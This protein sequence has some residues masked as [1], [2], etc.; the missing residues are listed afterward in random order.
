MK[1][2]AGLLNG[3]SKEGGR[4]Q[5]PSKPPRAPLKTLPPPE[6][7][8]TTGT[9]TTTRAKVMD[10]PTAKVPPALQGWH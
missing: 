6:H 1:E 4:A 5:G 3:L 10:R 7:R 9:C 8:I 2:A